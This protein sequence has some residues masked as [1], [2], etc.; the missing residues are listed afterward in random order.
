MGKGRQVTEILGQKGDRYW[1]QQCCG[2]GSG[3]RISTDTDSFWS[4][5]SGSALGIRIRI[6]IQEDHNEPQK[7]RKFKFWSARCSLSRNEYFSCSLDVLYW[8]L[9]I[10]KLQF[11]KKNHIFFSRNFFPI[12]GHQNPGSGS[13]LTENTRSGSVSALELEPM[14]IRNTGM[15]PARHWR[16]LSAN[17]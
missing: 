8:G 6:R 16:N 14:R 10:G 17:K 15:W 12:F 13:A 11:D 4:A 3:V 1:K 9:G 2:P 5:G 7:W